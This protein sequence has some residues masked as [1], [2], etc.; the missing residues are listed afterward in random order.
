[1]VE[2]L[3]RSFLW[4][5]FQALHDPILREIAERS[6]E[7]CLRCQ[8]GQPPR[9]MVSPSPVPTSSAYRSTPERIATPDVIDPRDVGPH[10]LDA[11][12]GLRHDMQPDDTDSSGDGIV[13]E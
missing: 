8:F 7:T 5:M 11:D 9:L 2:T 10:P 12:P 1:M 3:H 6:A 4:V 13:G